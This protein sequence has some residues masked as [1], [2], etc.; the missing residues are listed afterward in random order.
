MKRGGTIAKLLVADWK[1]FLSLTKK[2]R[3]VTERLDSVDFTLKYIHIC[4]YLAMSLGVQG[5]V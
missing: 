5:W 4:H 3:Q 2:T 1:L